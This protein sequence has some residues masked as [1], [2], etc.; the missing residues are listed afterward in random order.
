MSEARDNDWERFGRASREVSPEIRVLNSMRENPRSFDVASYYA[1]MLIHRA[2][3]VMLGEEGIIRGEEA[4]SILKGLK[5]VED[6]AENDP[7]LSGYM[8]TE[9]ALIREVGEVGG[10]MH[11]GR[12]R[13]DLGHTQRRIFYRDQVNRLISAVI[14]CRRK[15]TET[16]ERHKETVMPGYTHWRQAQP[17]TLAHYIMA[18][19]EAASR[20]VERLE[21]VYHRT[22]LSPLGSAAFAGTGW[23]V[24]RYR[25]MEF[26]GFDGL[27]ENTQDGV[28][29]ID[30]YMEL[31]AAMAIHMT[32]LS[33][34]AEDIQIW[35]SDEFKLIELD[36]AYAGTSSI[37]P[38][39]KNPL[40]LEQ[41]KSYAA[42]VLGNSVSVLASMKGV[43]YT[44]IVDRVMLEPMT[45][46][47]VV[48][49][50]N[51]MAGLVET[52]EPLYDN[53]LKRL[54]E[55]YSTMTDLADT[56]VRLFDISFR[57][58]HDIIVNV[59]I[60]AINHGIIAEEINPEMIEIAST[61]VLDR[62]LRINHEELDQAINPVL[63][64][65]RR[66]GIGGPAP[67]S[68]MRMIE[69]Q[70]SR[71]DEEEKRHEARVSRIDQ[72]EK[73]LVDAEMKFLD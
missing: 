66:N 45:M 26:L 14:E 37:M 18:H 70:K 17:I 60:E 68:V 47:T 13:N 19:V 39:K 52:L 1:Q 69:N 71:I 54:K 63:N 50:T 62:P 59:T 41:V 53:M 28:A 25:T 22:N 20:T 27:V 6:Q 10:K 72:A 67:E 57:Q 33:R 7:K 61:K 29:A 43:S 31:S 55:G 35:F 36:E 64:V 8:S 3:T 23:P 73:K 46:D 21:G 16:A 40:I 34:L 32:N 49:S 30:Y 44:N 42:E 2:H 56:L 5:A 11:I 24:N 48:G 12:S 58:A 65:N 38:Q 4:S 9:T 51:V 15:L